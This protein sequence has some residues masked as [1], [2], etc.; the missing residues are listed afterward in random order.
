MNVIDALFFAAVLGLAGIFVYGLYVME[1][2]K[3]LN[4]KHED[5]TNVK[6]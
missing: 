5:A 3:S 1:V 6:N 2:D 4:R